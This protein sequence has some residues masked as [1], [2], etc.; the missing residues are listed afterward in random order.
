MENLIKVTLI[1]SQISRPEK[2]RKTLRAL[3]LKK[4]NRP[5]TFK[6]SPSV[7]GMINQVNHLLKVEEITDESS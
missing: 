6:K 3:G 5:R 4:M 2:H 7:M 1:R